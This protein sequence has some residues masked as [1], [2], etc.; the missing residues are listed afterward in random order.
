MEKYTHE[1]QII[2]NEIKERTAKLQLLGFTETE[3]Q[4]IIFNHK[5]LSKLLITNEYKILLT[6]YHLE[7][8]MFPLVKAV[9]LLYL[10][11]PEGISFKCLPDFRSELLAIYKCISGRVHLDDMERSINGITDPTCNSINEVCSSIKT[12]FTKHM[13]GS[14]AQYYFI[15]GK[16]GERKK[17]LLNVNLIDWNIDL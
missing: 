17:I 7:I 11:H 8:P 15:T 2:I 3:L 6:D 12:A 5:K 1:T 9:Y 16:R 14:L 10:K 4:S 13:D